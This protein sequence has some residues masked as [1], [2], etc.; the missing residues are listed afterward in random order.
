[1][2]LSLTTVGCAVNDR[3]LV[4]VRHYDGE[5]A[6]M[7]TLNAWGLHLMTTAADG[8]VTLGRSQRSYVF[9]KE[10]ASGA[11]FPLAEMAARARLHE[12]TGEDAG[13]FRDLGEPLA[14]IVRTSGIALQTS[15][16][17]TGLLLGVRLRAALRVPA[18]GSR[19]LYLSYRAGTPPSAYVR[20]EE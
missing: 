14:T 20:K 8:G 2:L 5:T 7:V 1:V 18:D 15:G 13:A 19:V 11:A 4:R 6:R 10:G 12:S 17:R 16:S 9:A 3:G